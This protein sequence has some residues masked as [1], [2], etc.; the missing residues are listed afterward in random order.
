MGLDMYLYIEKYVSRNDYVRNEQGEIDV[1]TNSLFDSLTH[2]LNAESLVGDSGF[3]GYTVHIP[4]GYWRKANAIHNYI[5]NTFAGGEDNC[6][7]IS[8]SR[9]G[10]DCLRSICHAALF[11][12]RT[13][14]NHDLAKLHLPTAAGFFFGSLEYDE[15]Y[16]QDLANTIAIIDRALHGDKEKSFVYRASW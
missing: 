7:E 3:A 2:A 1:I 12:Y 9:E 16:F 10:L 6:Q 14:A 11:E 8:I 13:T 4:V 15:Y 5:V